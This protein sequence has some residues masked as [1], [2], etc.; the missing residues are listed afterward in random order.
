MMPPRLL[1]VGD[2]NSIVLDP[3]RLGRRPSGGR[4]GGYEAIGGNIVPQSPP[5]VFSTPPDMPSIITL[6]WNGG[7][8]D[9]EQKKLDA[10]AHQ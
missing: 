3:A 2:R 7:G 6:E 1:A 9:V 8:R 5:R 4:G 10:P